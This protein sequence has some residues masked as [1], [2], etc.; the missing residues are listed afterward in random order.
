[1]NSRAIWRRTGGS[2]DWSG[3]RG[4]YHGYTAVAG[5]AAAARR[6]KPVSA[7]GSTWTRCGTML[8]SIFSGATRMSSSANP[9]AP[10]G[11]RTPNAGCLISISTKTWIVTYHWRSLPGWSGLASFTLRANSELNSPARRMLTS[12]VADRLSIA[13]ERMLWAGHTAQVIRRLRLCKGSRN[14]TVRLRSTAGFPK[15]PSP[16][17]SYDQLTSTPTGQNA[18]KALCCTAVRNSH[19]RMLKPPSPQSAMPGASGRG[20]GRRWPDRAWCR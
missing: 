11:F 13:S 4:G 20:L 7:A 9:T 6:G 3:R 2:N 18:Q 15:K 12:C 10:G 5:S 1:M 19:I 17:R 16:S 8:A 14:A